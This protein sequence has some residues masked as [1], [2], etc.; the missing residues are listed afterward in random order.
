M[1]RTGFMYVVHWCSPQPCTPSACV[2]T[3]SWG[4]A[5]GVQA[6]KRDYLPFHEARELA[7]D[8]KLT[9]RAQYTLWWRETSPANLPANCA[10]A[11]AHDGWLSW[12][13]F[14]G[15]KVVALSVSRQ[16]EFLPFKEARELARKLQ[17]TSVQ[18]WQQ[19]CKEGNRPDGVPSKPSQVTIIHHPS[20]GGLY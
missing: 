1:L 14:L 15:C 5:G 6:A 19:L 16:S 12:G 7:R 10:S 8:L 17:L 9:T 18:Q 11:Y 13:D 3:L 2:Q 20:T 4:A